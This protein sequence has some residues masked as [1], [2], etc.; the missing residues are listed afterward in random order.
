MVDC[1]HGYLFCAAY[2]PRPMYKCELCSFKSL[3]LKAYTHHF[4]LHRSLANY[5]FPCGVTWCKRKF[6]TYE[7]FKSHVYR[8]HSNKHDACKPG[9]SHASTTELGHHELKILSCSVPRCSCTFKSLNDLFA[10]LRTHIDSK[11]DIECPYKDCKKRF[12][13]KSS[14][15]AHI[16]RCHRN[17]AASDAESV[18]DRPEHQIVENISLPVHVEPSLDDTEFY[19]DS[20]VGLDDCFGEETEEEFLQCLSVFYLKLQAKNLLPSSVIQSIISEFQSVHDI[21]KQI[22]R[23]RLDEKLNWSS[24]I[25][26]LH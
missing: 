4:S 17:C 12:C 20:S 21:E 23:K 15:S 8:D 13:K 19:S 10:H 2:T 22:V 26:V 11:V 3:S 14:F 1:N 16:S 9:F 7:S 24:Y 6:Q 5:Q 25:A 18:L